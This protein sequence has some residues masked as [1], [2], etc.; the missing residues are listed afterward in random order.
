MTPDPNATSAILS[1][2]ATVSQPLLHQSDDPD[3]GSRFWVEGRLPLDALTVEL[4]DSGPLACPLSPDAARA[5][6]AV[7]TP[8]RFGLREQT[9]L[10]TQVRDT[11]EIAADALTLHWREDALAGLLAEVAR[12]LGVDDLTAHPHGLLVY[13]PGQFFKPHQDTEKHAGMVATLVLV[14]PSPHIG[15]E[16]RIRHTLHEVGFASQHVQADA[17]RWFAFYADCRHEVLP[18]SDGTR[19]TLTFDLVLP[20]HALHTLPGVVYPPL[21]SALRAHFFPEQRP[22]TK[23]LVLLLDHEYSEHG[24]SWLLIK[25]DDRP[26][27]TALRAAAQSLGLTIHLALAEVR[28]VWSAEPVGNPFRRDAGPLKVEPID[29]IDQCLVLDHWLDEQGEALPNA[30]LTLNPADALHFRDT[31]DHF[32]VDQE[33]EGYMGNYG[34]TLQFWYRRAAVVIQSP[35][36][37][38]ILRFSSDF[39]T[40]LDN[41][42]ALARNPARKAEFVARFEAAGN[43]LSNERQRQGTALLSA[44]A[45]LAIALPDDE[46]AQRLCA[47]FEWRA[48]TPADAVVLAR[49]QSGRG[50]DWLCALVQVWRSSHQIRSAA[51]IGSSASSRASDWPQPLSAFLA[52]CAQAGVDPKVIEAIVDRGLATVRADDAILQKDTPGRRLAAFPER[53]SAMIELAQAVSHSPTWNIQSQRLLEHIRDTPA[54]YPLNRLGP[55]CLALPAA[56]MALPTAQTLRTGVIESLQH[57]LATP[58]LDADDHSMLD[59]KW[60]CRCNDCQPVIRWA[61]SRTGQ[62]LTLALAEHRRTHIKSA[63]AT[64]GCRIT[65]QVVKKGS[66]YRLVLDKP[67]DLHVQRMN[68]RQRWSD[69]LAKL[70]KPD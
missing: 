27:V 3:A 23:P 56:I 10:D 57:A 63:L 15:G 67:V 38:E 25:G 29:L 30:R 6:A 48:L 4:R 52:A 34:E 39:D 28:E 41:L 62:S 59:I 46:Q 9:L 12:G 58:A 44:Y 31:D 49:L 43:A 54:I 60:T 14:W 53:T 16:L 26:R 33:Y 68:Q 47:G 11:G 50:S 69:E 66:P 36:I 70:T 18:V 13:G 35:E 42:L 40:A 64:A 24:L 37:V 17:L 55:L 19:V 65:S 7:T 21:E 45:E 8:A 32:L 51:S 5:L 20:Q 2:L 22:P 61:E 1:A